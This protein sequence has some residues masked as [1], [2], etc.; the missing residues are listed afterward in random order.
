MPKS[1]SFCRASKLRSQVLSA[2]DQKT[3]I[4]ENFISKVGVEFRNWPKTNNYK[5]I[6]EYFGIATMME[7][8][9]SDKFCLVSNL[10]VKFYQQLTQNRHFCQFHLKNRGRSSEWDKNL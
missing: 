5:P 6:P 3:G 1:H 2:I 8:P 10:I 4:S 9:K 7:M